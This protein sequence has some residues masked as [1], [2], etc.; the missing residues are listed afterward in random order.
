MPYASQPKVKIAELTDD[1]CKFTIEDT[2]LSMANSL[3]RI[4]LSEVST[5]AIDWV[6]IENNTSVLH[7][8][9]I[10]HRV[11]LIPLTCEG[12]VGKMTDAR[13][14]NCMGFCPSCSIEF[15]LD[16]KVTGEN[17]KAVTSADLISSDPNVIPVTSRNKDED[18]EYGTDTED[19][20][21]V[22]LRK[23]QEL[24]LVAYARKGF[25]KEHAKW[26]PTSGV[27]FEY[28]PDNSLRHTTYPNPK[29]WPKSE[30]TQLEEDEQE[31]PFDLHGV[32]DKFYINVESVGC[33]K[34]ERI[35]LESMA[36]LK[37]KLSDLQAQHSHEIAADVLAIS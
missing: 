36:V 10:A 9:F 7:D 31:A 12:T 34:P 14:C 11:G 28:D 1:N 33:L 30:Y 18:N 3:R 2:D 37:K 4:M 22:K 17:T 21:I 20:V 27:A 6:Q 13:E 23:G 19:I 15:K 8:E 35:I 24:K 5:I 26:N 32:P 29:E 25:G 16:V